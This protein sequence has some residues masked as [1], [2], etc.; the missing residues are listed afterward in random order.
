MQKFRSRYTN[1]MGLSLKNEMGLKTRWDCPLLKAG[2]SL[3]KVEP[4]LLKVGLSPFK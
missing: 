2:L 3:L 1:K 4:S